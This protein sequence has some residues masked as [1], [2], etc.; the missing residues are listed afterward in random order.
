MTP[1]LQF[2][3]QLAIILVS[4]AVFTIISKALKQPVILGYILAGFLVGPNLGL[5]P[6]LDQNGV[7]E[8][9]EIGIIFLMFG[10]GLEFSFKKLL[11]IGSSA[12]I[13]AG[14][15]C[16]GMFATGMVVGRLMGWTTMECSFLGGMLGMS[17]TAVII[18][19]YD[20]MGLKNKPYAPLIFGSCVFEDLIAVLLMVLLSTMAVTGRFQGGEMLQAVGK[21]VFFLILWFVIGIYLL[22]LLFKKARKFI[23]SEILL[24]VGLGL[25]FGM[26]VFANYVGFSSALGAFVMGSILAE[27]IE[28]EKIEHLTGNIKDMFGAVFFVSVGMMV[29]PAVIAQHW[30]TILILAI[31]VVL[32]RLVFSTWGAL[33]AGAGLDT[34]VHASFTL[35]Q[36]GEFAF[37]LAGLGCSLGVLR[38]FIYPVVIAVTVLTTFTTPYMIRLGDPVAAWLYKKIPANIISKID[39]DPNA[40]AKK[41]KAERSEWKT[42]LK[43]FFLRIALYSVIIIA[44]IILCR[45][46]LPE[47]LSPI[48]ENLGGRYL[49]NAANVSIVLL[50]IAP[51]IYGMCITDK[52]LKNSFNNLLKKNRENRWLVLSLICF[53]A[54]IATAFVI[55]AISKFISLH[56]WEVAILSLMGIALFMFLARKSAMVINRFESTFLLNLNEK[57]ESDRRK[58]PVTSMVRDHLTNYNVTLKR[59]VISPDFSFIG[60]TLREMP[61]RK[62]TEANIIKIQRG[63]KSILVPSGNEV[64]YPGDILLAVG[65][66]EQLEKFEQCLNEHCEDARANKELANAD[67][68]SVD[69]ITLGAESPMCGRTL[70]QIDMRKTGCMVIS[71]IR[72]GQ[73]ITNPGAEFKF[74]KGDTLWLAGE[75]STVEWYKQD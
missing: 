62:K 6:Q 43:T 9:S 37:I 70:R 26:V 49:A 18:K 68:F 22:P 60:K 28:G 63:S 42:V 52:N 75:K 57:E 1:E 59:L 61:F 27:T 20:D 64:I 73:V 45:N 7:H 67:S 51:F 4:A 5:F 48:L 69:T 35:A 3:T 34:A 11:R 47:H 21:L 50:L 19:A 72:N 44:V 29:D 65:T 36:L 58:A 41:S 66:T 33:L 32:G 55:F 25:C 38:G 12:L 10:L 17:S 46:L 40:S 30:G 71:V 53:R 74:E 54:I 39:P 15:K 8:W 13:T 56:A 2:V 31:V 24:L 14:V 16:I 23:T